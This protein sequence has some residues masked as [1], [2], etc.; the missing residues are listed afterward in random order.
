MPM[1]FLPLLILAGLV[2]VLP[3]SATAQHFDPDP[4]DLADRV[5]VIFNANWP[6]DDGDGV[7]DSEQV[8]RYYAASRRIPSSNVLGLNCTTSYYYSGQTGWEAFWDEIAVP[9]QDYIEVTLGSREAV[10][11]IVLCYG[12]PYQIN[13]PGWSRRALDT[14]LVGLWDMGDRTTPKYETYGR[15]NSYHDPAPTI[16]DDME[17]FDPITYPTGGETSYLVAR[18]DGQDVEHAIELVE[19]ALYGDAYLSPLP[20]YWNGFAYA[21]TR[22]GAYTWADL[23]NYPYNHWAYANADKDMAYGRQWMETPGFTLRWE[24]YGTE[25]G[26]PGATFE[27]GSSAETAP[28]A[29]FYEGWYNYNKYQPVFE[30]LVG[31]AACDLNSNSIARIRDENPGTFL[32]ES[33]KIGLTCGVGCIAEPYLNGH[34]FPETFQYYLLMKGFTFGEAARISD[35]KLSWTNMYVGDLLYQPMRANKVAL[36]DD[37]APAPCEVMENPGVNAGE[38][39]FRTFL[40]SIGGLPDVGELTLHF[41]ADSNFGNTVSGDD[42]RPRLFHTATIT[43]LGADEFIHYRADYTDPAGNVGVGNEFILHTGLDHQPV[44]ARATSAAL[45]YPAGTEFE[46]EFVFGAQAGATSLTSWAANATSA[47]MGWSN[48]N[49]KPHFDSLGASYFESS[50]GEL[51]SIRITVPATLPVGSYQIDVSASS[52]A[53]A[54]SDSLI[55]DLY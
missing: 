13:P 42:P 23:A 41:G 9:V 10:N 31:S 20:G 25:I 16:H 52:A 27:D 43:G 45:S 35:P 26:E 53:G 29:M 50:G 14:T 37:V 2:A 46:I 36:L 19:F 54:D 34:P 49:L 40:N 4:E 55:I 3:A 5:L 21:D 22:Y 1:K 7:G 48:L 30:W 11:G 24:P 6:D 39:E 8:A 44:L 38:R 18:L 28:R 12:M 15:Y 33:F 17:R 51:R 47:V 32:G